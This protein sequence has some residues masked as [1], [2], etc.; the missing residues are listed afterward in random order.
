MNSS[1][2]DEQLKHYAIDAQQHPPQSQGRQIALR[3]LVNGILTSGRLC[4]P[5]AGQ[6]RGRYEDIYSEALQE[7]MLFICENIDKYSPERGAVL[8]WVN[9]LLRRRFF[10]EAIPKVLDKPGVVRMSL[11]DIEHLDL[12]PSDPPKTLTELL[13]ECVDADPDNL[14]KTAH[15]AGQPQA[16]F[17]VIMK[18]RLVGSS[19]DDISAEFNTNLS[20][21]SSFYYRGLARFSSVLRDY[22][23]GAIPPS[24]LVPDTH[25]D[26]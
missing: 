26:H 1:P 23:L 2:L 6:Y 11:H 8:V 19:W 12:A 13:E 5:Q 21:I 4:R 17:Q 7:L 22:C 3:K 9:M 14:F 15:L 24:N 25:H 18:R 10:N 16:T 20:T